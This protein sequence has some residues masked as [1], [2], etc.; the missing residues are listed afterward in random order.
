MHHRDTVQAFTEAAESFNRAAVTRLPETLDQLLEIAQPA[1]G[2]RW[3]DAACG[4]GVVSRALAPMVGEVVG[5]DVT[6]AMLEVAR[7]EASAAGIGNVRFAAGDLTDLDLPDAA[8]D[9]ALC[10]FAR[11]LAER[12]EQARR[13]AVEGDRVLI[14]MWMGRWRRGGRGGA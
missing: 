8:F 1:V 5:V 10:R 11:A 4:P 13:F 12:P 3:L 2:Q 9:G 14:H 7:R 6:P